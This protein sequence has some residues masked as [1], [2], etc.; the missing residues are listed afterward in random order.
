M[1]KRE[2][3]M[4]TLQFKKVGRDVETTSFDCGVESINK[5]IKNSYFPTIMQHAYAYSIM[6]NGLI[7]GYY[8]V[9]FREIEL[10]E[11]PDD[12]AEL[13]PCIKEGKISSVHIRFIAIDKRYQKKKIG[14]SSLKT[15]IKYISEFAENMPIRVI[16]I[17]AR[18]DL[19]DWYYKIGFNKMMKNAVGQDCVT[20]A[21]Y[22]D[23]LKDGNELKKYL[24]DVLE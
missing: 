2:K 7:L 10:K 6:N 1:H 8:Q 20:E 3:R 12:I 19:L 13:D 15:I 24:E 16:T 18:K 23:C 5:Y 14:T 22:F 17:D 9:L 11:F 4:E 21:M